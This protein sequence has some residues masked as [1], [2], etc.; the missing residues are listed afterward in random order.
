MTLAVE[1]GCLNP[2]FEFEYWRDAMSW[3]Q[4]AYRPAFN[5]LEIVGDL[6]TFDLNSVKVDLY[7]LTPVIRT[8]SGM[9]LCEV[10]DGLVGQQVWLDQHGLRYWKGCRIKTLTLKSYSMYCFLHPLEYSTLDV[11]HIHCVW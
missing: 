3:P 8:P 5:L 7:W 2:S 11:D 1:N 10:L 4:C 6:V 9:I